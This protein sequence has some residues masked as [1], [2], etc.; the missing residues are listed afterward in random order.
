M[1]L[2]DY[3]IR[4]TRSSKLSLVKQTLQNGST[5][6]TPCSWA[7]LSLHRMPLPMLCERFHLSHFHQFHLP[8]ASLCS[9]AQHSDYLMV[10]HLQNSLLDSIFPFKNCFY[11]VDTSPDNWLL[12]VFWRWYW[13][14]LLLITL[15][16]L[17]IINIPIM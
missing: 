5:Q 6:S 10:S 12:Y 11:V 17:L 3:W 16:Y 13:D 9:S 14:I 8:L 7:D 1:Y 4:D 15:N 2:I